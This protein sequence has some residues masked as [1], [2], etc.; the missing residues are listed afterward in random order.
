MMA[1]P[2]EQRQIPDEF[3]FITDL[4]Q[5][6]S[7]RYHRQTSSIVVTL[8]H[9]MCLFFAGSFAPAYSITIS[10]LPSQLQTA[11]NKRNCLLLQMH[12]D[13]ALKVVPA[14]GVVRYLPVPDECFGWNGRTIAGE[15]AE[16]VGRPSPND[17]NSP[18]RRRR[19]LPVRGTLLRADEKILLT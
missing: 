7:E 18:V 17:T 3:T 6:L 13:K 16:A 8:Q 15:T 19:T 11:T 4:S 12:L 14:R 9:R 10:A 5:H 2:D 1:S